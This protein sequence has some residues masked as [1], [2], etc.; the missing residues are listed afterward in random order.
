MG[1]ESSPPPPLP[2]SL[3]FLE[4][5]PREARR[6]SS[7]TSSAFVSRGSGGG[8]RRD[9]GEAI[10]WAVPLIFFFLGVFPSSRF[11][12]S[13]SSSA[14]SFCFWSRCRC[15]FICSRRRRHMREGFS[16]VVA[17]SP[18]G[19][20]ASSSASTSSGG[21]CREGVGVLPSAFFFPFPFFPP[22]VRSGVFSSSSSSCPPLSFDCNDSSV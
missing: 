16:R 11:A 9:A 4:D 8:R 7:S 18:S 13:S 14:S 15:F 19:C 20:G 12:R 5:G 2:L 22:C 6:T 1:R 10:G 17:P 21:G 3:S